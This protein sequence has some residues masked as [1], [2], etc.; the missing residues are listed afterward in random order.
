M[1]ASDKEIMKESSK[2]SKLI[3]K[4]IF[5]DYKDKPHEDPSKEEALDTIE[6]LVAMQEIINRMIVRR[7]NSYK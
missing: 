6:D 5:N 3:I 2:I 1:Q 4:K 7:N